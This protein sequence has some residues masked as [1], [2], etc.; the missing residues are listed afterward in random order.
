MCKA[1]RWKKASHML[2]EDTRHKYS[3][4]KV[5]GGHKWG[6]HCRPSEL[7][8][9]KDYLFRHT[10]E[11]EC[12]LRCGEL[13]LWQELFYKETPELQVTTLAFMEGKC[14][15]AELSE[16]TSQEVR[17]LSLD[18]G[19]SQASVWAGCSVKANS[20]VTSA[21]GGSSL[22]TIDS[23]S[24]A[25]GPM[26]GVMASE[27]AMS[28]ASVASGVT[29]V[30]SMASTTVAKW[31]DLAQAK[32]VSVGVGDGKD[33]SKDSKV[34][35][36]SPELE[37]L[38]ERVKQSLVRYL[39]QDESEDPDLLLAYYVQ[40]KLD[41]LPW[42]EE[43]SLKVRIDAVARQVKAEHEQR[44]AEQ[45]SP[46]QSA[47]HERGIVPSDTGIGFQNAE[48]LGGG[49]LPDGTFCRPLVNKV[50]HVAAHVQVLA[51]ETVGGGPDKA[52]VEAQAG[53]DECVGKEVKG[54]MRSGKEG[55]TDKTVVKAA[56]RGC[57]DSTW[58]KAAAKM[59]GG[60]WTGRETSATGHRRPVAVVS[61]RG[62]TSLAGRW[63]QGSSE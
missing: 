51:S 25:A 3:I 58:A 21:H 14:L 35:T 37:L 46:Q 34:G 60:P 27:K 7:Q 10:R 12:S 16:N 53:H 28:S 32:A 8:A 24:Q 2:E 38:L 23:R 42:R 11:K 57:R 59:F 29:K 55:A 13:G 26:R 5:P 19:T 44:R 15:L 47:R 40:V 31:V 22:G 33:P 1:K 63:A 18:R 6:H 4:P 36:G 43:V 48:N 20:S 62:W 17:D 50:Q 45:A 39:E 54:L 52:T 9:W 61:A 56:P 41:T 49:P 30:S